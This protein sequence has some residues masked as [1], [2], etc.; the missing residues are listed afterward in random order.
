MKARL[1]SQKT[2]IQSMQKKK[3]EIGCGRLPGWNARGADGSTH[4]ENKVLANNY[5]RARI[6]TDFYWDCWSIPHPQL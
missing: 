1:E 4:D 2:V 3:E 6:D 5:N